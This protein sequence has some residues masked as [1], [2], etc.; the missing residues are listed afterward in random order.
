MTDIIQELRGLLA[1]ERKALR[2]MKE[3]GA[4][5]DVLLDTW[6]KVS[7]G[8]NQ[9]AIAALP[10]LLDRLEAAESGWQPIETASRDGWHAPILTCRMGEPARWFGDEPVGGY[11]EPPEAAYWNEYGDCWTPCHR[12]H[13]A[14][15]PTHWMPLPD[16]PAIR[17]VTL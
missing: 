1:A 10:A 5:N 17:E 3:S 9:A 14:W 15:E 2:D 6:L 12:P 16:A 4:P 11:A 7:G 13:D 8:L